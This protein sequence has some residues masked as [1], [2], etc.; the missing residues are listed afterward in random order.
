[1]NIV[2][3]ADDRKKELMIQFCTAYKSILAKH[4]LSA[5]AATGR[6]VADATDLPVSLFLSRNQGGHQQ[7]DARITYNEVDLI[8]MFADPNAGDA[9]EDERVMRTLHLCDAYNVPVATNLASA[10]MMILGLQ[11]GDLDWREM[12]RPKKTLR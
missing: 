9:W 5:T 1:M 2:L 10:E 4:E 7:V 3:M 11:R 8:L 6:L 12:I